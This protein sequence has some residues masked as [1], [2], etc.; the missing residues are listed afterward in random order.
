[1]K[2]PPFEYLG[3]QF[4]GKIARLR[5][6]TM[7]SFYRKVTYAVRSEA[8]HL[9]K[10]YPDK[11]AAEIYSGLNLSRLYEKFGRKRDFESF[12][13]DKKKWNFWSY[14]TR[15]SVSMGEMGKDIHRQMRNYR[16]F[17]RTHLERELVR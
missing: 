13:K 9:A 1:M 5:S 12:V 2:M 8:R 15:A 16:K 11:D 4:D 17:V 10:R 14:V 3:F 7:S 6:G